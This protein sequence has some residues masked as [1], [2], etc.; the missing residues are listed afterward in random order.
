[1]WQWQNSS[2]IC[3]EREMLQPHPALTWAGIKMYT[4]N[5]CE[6]KIYLVMQIVTERKGPQNNNKSFLCHEFNVRCLLSWQIL[7]CCP[8]ALRSVKPRAGKH[9]LWPKPEISRLFHIKNHLQCSWNTLLGK[10]GPP[11]RDFNIILP[12]SKA[13]IRNVYCKLDFFSSM[14]MKYKFYWAYHAK[15][16]AYQ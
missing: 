9:I 13:H 8:W 3:T 1:M 12:A 5:L 15:N 4:Y 11:I 6:M 2:S 10:P 7:E 16:I 14:Q